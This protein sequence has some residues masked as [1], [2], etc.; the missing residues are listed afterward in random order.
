MGPKN[1][2]EVHSMLARVFF[3]RFSWTMIPQRMGIYVPTQTG[4]NHRRHGRVRVEGVTCDLGVVIDL[5]ASGMRVQRRWRPPAVVGGIEYVRLASEAGNLDLAAR[6][7]WSGRTSLFTYE[8]GLYFLELDGVQREI[9][10]EILRTSMNTTG[11][12]PR[13]A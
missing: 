10:L 4:A 13:A 11:Q 1:R 5:S 9:L 2:T 8:S 12:L 6:V 3:A 7:A